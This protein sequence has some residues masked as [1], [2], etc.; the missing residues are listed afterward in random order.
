VDC[1]TIGGARHQTVEDIE[2][3]DEMALADTADGR[4][5]GHLPNIFG[6]KRKQRDTGSAARRSSRS[7]ATGMAG[8]DHQNV[9]HDG[10]LAQQRFT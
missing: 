10:A 4:V 8:A 7:F 1:S 9:V 3:T 5:T 2:L 6:T